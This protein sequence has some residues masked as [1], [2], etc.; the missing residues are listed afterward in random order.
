MKKASKGVLAASAGVVLLIGGGGSL[1]YWTET[2]PITGGAINAGH[3]NLI[4]DATNTGCGAWVLDG[5]EDVPT[6]YNPGDPLVPGD[7]LTRDCAYTIQAEGNHLRAGVTVG[8]L[9]FTGGSGDFG[10]MLDVALTDLNVNNVLTSEFTE[11]NDGDKLS[12]QVTV[13]FD[14]AA[15]DNTEDM[16]TVLDAITLTAS[17]IHD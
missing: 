3:M 5:D 2:E 4:T 16:S 17:Q 8:P 13:T 11:A 6:D 1:A 7:V 12:A 15:L 10:G 9:N 14:A